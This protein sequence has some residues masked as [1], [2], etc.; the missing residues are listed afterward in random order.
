M[1]C[2]QQF[3]QI[4]SSMK[5]LFQQQ[6]FQINRNEILSIFNQF[7]IHLLFFVSIKSVNRQQLPDLPHFN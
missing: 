2:I 7:L 4:M 1:L 6:R 5:P 3:H